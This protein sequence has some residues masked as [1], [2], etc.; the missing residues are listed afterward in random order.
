MTVSIITYEY[1]LKFC[2]LIQYAQYKT[3]NISAH[4]DSLVPGPKT[5]PY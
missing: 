1:I 4:K 5:L 2:W 3:D